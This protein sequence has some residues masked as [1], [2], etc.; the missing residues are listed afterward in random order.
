MK[1]RVF[2]TPLIVFLLFLFAGVLPASAENLCTVSIKQS[3]LARDQRD[4]I[5]MKCM[6]SNKTKLNTKSCIRIANSMEYSNNAEDARLI[7]LYDLKREPRLREC[8]AIAEAMEYPDSGDEVRWECI[9]RHNR[10]I[11]KKECRKVAL[12]MSYPSNSKRALLYCSDELLK[13]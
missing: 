12:K 8:L 3:S 5:R 10:V 9:R 11:S 2:S 13:N 1:L 4:D 6:K 7:C